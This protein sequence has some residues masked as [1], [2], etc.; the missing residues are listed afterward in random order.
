[1]VARLASR[2]STLGMARSQGLATRL[3]PASSARRAFSTSGADEDCWGSKV[4]SSFCV[5]EVD[6]PNS[7][8]SMG[9]VARHFPGALPGQIVDLVTNQVLLQRGFTQSNTLLAHATCP[10]EINSNNPC[11]DLVVLLRRRWKGAFPLGGLAGLPF[12]GETGWGAFE[13][14]VPDDG[15]IFLFFGPHVGVSSSGVVGEVDRRGQCGDSSACGAAL[16]ALGACNAGAP[17]RDDPYDYQQSYITR[18]VAERKHEINAAV[19]PV[20][21]LTHVMY[22]IQMEFLKKMISAHRAKT[23]KFHEIAVLG[24]IQINTGEIE[25]DLFLPLMFEV[26]TPGV[27]AANDGWDG[28]A[29]ADCLEALTQN[30]PGN[31]DFGHV[32][33]FTDPI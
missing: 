15:K 10:D 31:L 27:D 6:Y 3:P 12:V 21:S 22:D 24:G 28:W 4:R 11:D 5:N 33:S 7:S 2:A 18:R 32:H 8:T 23:T 20:T 13:A 19:S 16:A 9:S 30:L 29:T 1:M 14:H 26:H 25:P 17:I